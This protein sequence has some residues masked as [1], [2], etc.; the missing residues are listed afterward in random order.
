V[1]TIQFRYYF[2]RWAFFEY[3][4]ATHEL[5]RKKGIRNIYAFKCS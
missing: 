5:R 2:M 1:S 4:H 3:S